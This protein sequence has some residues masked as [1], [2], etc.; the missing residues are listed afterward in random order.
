MKEYFE[1]KV[2]SRKDFSD[3]NQI[4]LRTVD[5]SPDEYS[6]LIQAEE[7]NGRFSEELLNLLCN[8]DDG[9]LEPDKCD[10]YE[11][12]KERFNCSNL[13]L[14]IRWLSQ[15]GSQLLIEK[16][17]KF[18]YI[19]VFNNRR[20]PKM[21]SDDFH[22]SD[23]Y[24]DPFLLSEI[25]FHIH[26]KILDEKPLEYLVDFFR[27]LFN[28]MN[29]EYGYLAIEDEI[30][31]RHNFNFL[32]DGVEFSEYKGLE[33]D[34]C[35]PGVY[36]LTAFGKTITEF[37]DSEFFKKPPCYKVLDQRDGVFIFK[38]AE[39]PNYYETDLERSYTIIESFNQ[40]FFFDRRFPDK[41]YETPF[42]TKNSNNSSS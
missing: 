4:Q 22:L 1:L 14:P 6:E 41:I 42:T 32:K 31:T 37:L 20:I 35:L 21:W 34:D 7:I 29:G 36:W 38:T 24:D 11:P 3:D 9:F 27:F 17:H 26:K 12:I 30:H 8:Y 33:I 13:R 40:S 25:S 39:H 10:V 18:E 16:K 28:K 5:M 15:L 23:N 19:G 2:Y